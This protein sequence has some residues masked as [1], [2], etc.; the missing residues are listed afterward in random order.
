VALASVYRIGVSIAMQNGVS[1]VLRVIQRDLFGLQTQVDL[2]AG[3]FTRMK[4]AAL[5]AMGIV[6]AGA[7]LGAWWE[8]AKAGAEI[9]NQQGKMLQL[10]VS[11]RDVMKETAVA[12]KA[13]SQISGS[14]TSGNM[15][16]LIVLR[17]QL[18]SLQNA[19]TALPAYAK[20]QFVLASNGYDPSQLDY[21]IKALDVQGAF[22]NKKTGELDASQFATGLKEAI[23]AV[24]TT[25]GLLN[26]QGFY[27]AS[28]LSN[29]AGQAM[30]TEM[31][32][33][34]MTEVLV[35]LGN[36]GARGLE[37]A[38]TD[39]IGG[40]LSKA[41]VNMLER[42]RL[43]SAGA[44]KYSGGG[45]Y[46]ADTSKLQGADLLTK[47]DL[48][49]WLK[50]YF[51]GAA[52]AQG[53]SALQAGAPFQQTLQSLVSF[54]STNWPQIQRS[55]EQQSQAQNTNQYDEAKN[56]FNGATSDFASALHNLWQVLGVPAAQ[57]AI[58]VLKP[59]TAGL[60]EFT[61]WLG[62][63]PTY[64]KMIDDMLLGLGVGLTVLGGIAVVGAIAG[65]VGA[66]GTLALVASG[67]VGVAT[68]FNILEVGIKRLE[69]AFPS[70]FPSDDHSHMHPVHT[71][72]RFSQTYYAPNA[73]W[74]QVGGNVVPMPGSQTHGPGAHGNGAPLGSPSNPLHAVITNA[75]DVGKAAAGG[76]AAHI[77]RQLDAP[78]SGT[79]G[80]NP[81]ATAP[82]SAASSAR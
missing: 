46:V 44:V 59:L 23:A 30:G 54:L 15:A 80:Y 48:I 65:M 27:Q 6:A 20:A 31:Y 38:A 12:M 19:N 7:A 76:A 35:A 2:T 26:G 81:A 36:R 32:L 25:G 67:I 43:I 3:G 22:V 58:Q 37:Y 78:N 71:G 8:L 63:H 68:A 49:D 4:A 1:S 61:G 13:A 55:A 72:G 11:Y 45:R 53:L 79:S 41:Q 50:K 10:G 70:I 77:S 60:R 9:T 21:F 42:L 73:G 29:P 39:F 28:R 5:G 18:G 62:T 14:T 82:G 74:Q 66:G 40:T 24:L 64:V 17:N 57:T 47:G 69:Q 51:L 75:G 56:Q 16:A 33:K 34:N 52:N